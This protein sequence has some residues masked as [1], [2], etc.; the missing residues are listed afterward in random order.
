MIK[1][2]GSSFINI[3]SITKYDERCIFVQWLGLFEAVHTISPCVKVFDPILD[4]SE[5]NVI[6]SVNINVSFNATYRKHVKQTCE[7]QIR[8]TLLCKNFYEA[9]DTISLCF[10]VFDPKLDHSE[11]NVIKSVNI[12]FSLNVTYRNHV[13]HTCE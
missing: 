7:E 4:H 6:K 13:K 3:L 5:H 9:V 10:K 12:K 2:K 1:D 8:S 11:H